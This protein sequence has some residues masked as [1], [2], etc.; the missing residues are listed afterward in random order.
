MVD[1]RIVSDVMVKERV[2][3][4]EL[5]KK[6][7]FF[8]ALDT[9]ELTQV[10]DKLAPRRF[11]DGEVLIRQGEM[12]DAFFLLR[13]GEVDVLVTDGQGQRKVA[14]L[15]FGRYFGERSL[16]TG[17]VRNATVVGRGGGVVYTLDKSAFDTAISGTP[18]LKEQLQKS[19]FGR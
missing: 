18:T 13:K 14:S 5:L 8:A 16:I 2:L 17:E 19:Y 9:A 15:D 7:E 3:V 4:A 6:I 12:G 10:A 1:G 11:K